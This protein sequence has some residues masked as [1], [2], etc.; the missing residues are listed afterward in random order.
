MAGGQ[1]DPRRAV[2]VRRRAR[3]ASGAGAALHPRDLRGNLMAV[4]VV[5]F[6][7]GTLMLGAAPGTDFS[8][9]VESLGLNVDKNE[10]DP[11]TVLCGDSVPGSIDYAYSLAGTLL[12]DIGTASGIV[13]YSWDNAGEQVAFTY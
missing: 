12:Q 2:A 10:G 13:E 8:C 1:G 11:I 5:R 6:G 7:P 3:T 4:N 9:Q